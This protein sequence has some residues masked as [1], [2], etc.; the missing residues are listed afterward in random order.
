MVCPPVR[1]DKPRALVSGL[2]PAHV[3]NH[4]ITMLYHLHV[5]QCRPGTLRDSSC[6]S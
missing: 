6:Q 2:S 5:H 1:G 3:D 4:G